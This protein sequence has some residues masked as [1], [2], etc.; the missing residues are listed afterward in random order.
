[1][2]RIPA[3]VCDRISQQVKKFQKTLVDATKRD[4]NES[5]TALI[6]AEMIAEIMGYKKLEEITSEYA[7]RGN[8]AD[9][10]VKVGNDVRFLIEVKAANTELKESHVTQVVNYGANQGVDWALL[11]NATRWQAYKISFD[12]PVDRTLVME[13]D[14]ASVS[15]KSDE[16]IEFFGNLSREVFTPSSMTQMFRSKQ[17]MGKFSIAAILL[18][19]PVVAMVRRELKRLA[20]GL[21]PD[22]D[23]IRAIIEND[24]VKRELTEGEEAKAAEKA[25]KKALRKAAKEKAEPAP[26]APVPPTPVV[27]MK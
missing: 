26:T 23:E 20:D 13:I 24:V 2:A 21:N 4:V 10:A 3:R 25:V 5:D 7:V 15:P 22:L 16:V 18:S 14:L 9:L 17:A 19:D 27:Q 11:T 8:Y 12:K 1:M 6:I